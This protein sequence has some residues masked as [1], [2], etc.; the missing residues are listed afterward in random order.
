[1]VGSLSKT[2]ELVILHVTDIHSALE[3]VEQLK[4]WLASGN[5]KLD[6]VLISGDIA[7]APMD[8]NLTEEQEKQYQKDLQVVVDSFT[9]VKSRVYFIPGNVSI[10][11]ENLSVVED[12]IEAT[13]LCINDALYS[14]DS[15]PTFWPLMWSV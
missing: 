9:S 14:R 3:R 4:S 7:N 5:H 11:S 8:W 1:V 12:H 10:Y 15:L 13:C 6:V 2:M